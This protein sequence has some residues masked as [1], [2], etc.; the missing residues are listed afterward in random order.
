ME[1]YPTTGVL[2]INLGGPDSLDSVKPFLYNLFSDPDIMGLNRILLKPLAWTLARRRAP[3]V[4]K[5]Y[6]LIGGKSPIVKLTMQQ[7][8]ALEKALAPH[9]GFMVFVAMRYSYPFIEDVVKE[10]LTLPFRKIIV[11]PLYPHYSMTTT[12]SSLNEFNRVW[13]KIGSTKIEISRVKEWYD[14][15]LYID[16]LCETIQKT[17]ELNRLDP[18]NT[19]IVYSAHGIP[20]KFINQGDPYAKEIERTVELIA[21]RLE[22]GEFH[23]GY[24]SRVGPMKW[25]EPSTEEVLKQLGDRGVRNIILV[26]VS[27]VSDHIETLYEM[28]ILLKEKAAGFGIDN[29]YRAPALNNSPRFIEALK[30]IVIET[31]I[32]AYQTTYIR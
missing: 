16:A 22:W 20:M 7:G 18:S 14:N 12:G 13:E 8:K 6:S 10:M 4:K 17:M 2:L 3:A 1:K 9:G 28:D 29:F 25:L 27:F 30:D 31:Y 11:L 26:P 5:Y 23:L 24:Q 21:D 15:P 19:H 32:S